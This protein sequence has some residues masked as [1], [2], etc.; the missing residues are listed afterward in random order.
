MNKIKNYIIAILILMTSILYYRYNKSRKYL[1]DTLVNNKAYIA[2]I[3]NVKKANRQFKYDMNTLNNLNDSIS[4]LLQ[5]TKKELKIKD[6]NI[7]QL[8]YM[9]LQTQKN[10]T[11]VFKDTI[12]VENLKIDTLLKDPYRELKIKLE[13]PNKIEIETLFDNPISTI[14]HSKKEYVKPRK[15]IWLLRLFQKKH[16]VVEATIN[17]HNPYSKQK[18]QRFIKIIK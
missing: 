1:E 9:Q 6:K 18:R 11:V 3:T 4:L 10:D 15:K 14:I 17:I 2:E 16:T 12:F 5:N 13:Y 7:E 8:Q